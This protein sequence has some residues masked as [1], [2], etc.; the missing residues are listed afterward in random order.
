MKDEYRRLIRL[1][2]TV[3]AT[4]ANSRFDSYEFS[5]LIRSSVTIPPEIRKLRISSPYACICRN[6]DIVCSWFGGVLDIGSARISLCMGVG[7]IDDDGFFA[8]CL[9]LSPDPQLLLRVELEKS[10]RSSH[11][12]HRNQA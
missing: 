10:L 1:I 12:A 4:I 7:V 5:I 6:N 3:Q 9:H 8:A 2:I 11:I